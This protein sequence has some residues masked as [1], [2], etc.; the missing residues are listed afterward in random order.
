MIQANELRLGNWLMGAGTGE[1]HP[2]QVN[3][4]NLRQLLVAPEYA[5]AIP[6]T[7]EILEMCG[8]EFD[9]DDNTFKNRI[10]LQLKD[11][12]FYFIEAGMLLDDNYYEPSVVVKYLHQLQNLYFVLTGKELTVNL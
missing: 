1:L 8:F 11:S 4:D 5:A 9:G 6:L 3:V 10:L 7:P 12:T 2:I